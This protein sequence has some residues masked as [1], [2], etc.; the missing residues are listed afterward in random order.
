MKE[1]Q[2]TLSSHSHVES[3]KEKAELIYAES[4]LVVARKGGQWLVTMVKRYK[5]PVINLGI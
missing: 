5:Y 4:R 1:R 2:N 3:K